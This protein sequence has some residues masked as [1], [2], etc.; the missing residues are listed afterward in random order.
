M[1]ISI[2]VVSFKS[3]SLQ[4]EMNNAIQLDAPQ[5]HFGYSTLPTY[6]LIVRYFHNPKTIDFREGRPA[7]GAFGLDLI[8]GTI[9][10]SIVLCADGTWNS[11]HAD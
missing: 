5:G 4:R 1:C 3:E 9:M 2:K 6:K 11:A 10:K 8:R 7:C